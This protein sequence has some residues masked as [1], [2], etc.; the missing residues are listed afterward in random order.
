MIYSLN[1]RL[2][3]PQK[4]CNLDRNDP[5]A[6][7]EAYHR[8]TLAFDGATAYALLAST[9]QSQLSQNLL[10]DMY[11]EMKQEP[12]S[13]YLFKHMDFRIAETVYHAEDLVEVACEFTQPNE[14]TL[15]ELSHRFEK[16]LDRGASWEDACQQIKRFLNPKKWPNTTQTNRY[17]LVR[18]ANG[19][20]VTRSLA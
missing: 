13:Q 4:D 18:E 7:L 2:T 19:W 5:A 10:V 16:S 14:T 8:A 3:N 12:I 11:N 9:D 15:K 17:K 1:S 20:A 6:V